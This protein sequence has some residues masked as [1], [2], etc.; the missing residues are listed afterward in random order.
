[1]IRPQQKLQG[2]EIFKGRRWLDQSFPSRKVV[3]ILMKQ[4]PIDCY[5][6]HHFSSAIIEGGITYVVIMLTVR[7]KV[8]WKII[9]I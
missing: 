7:D 2:L 4:T 8:T 5:T 1:M 6:E 3:S 9:L